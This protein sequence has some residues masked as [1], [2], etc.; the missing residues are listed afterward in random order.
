MRRRSVI[1]LVAL[2]SSLLASCRSPTSRGGE[3][4]PLVV[5]S[6]NVL[7]LFDA[8]DDGNEYPGYSVAQGLW[9]EAK[10][11]ARLESIA[12][13]A[14]RA[15]RPAGRG[16]IGPDILCL[17]EIEKKAILDDLVEGPLAKYGYRW[18]AFARARGSPIGLGI[19][20]RIP[21]KGAR[22]WGLDLGAGRERP[23]LEAR[24]SWEGSPVAIFLN[25]WKSKV[26]GAESTELSRVQS[27]AL[28]SRAIETERAVEPGLAVV[29]CGDFNEGP[30]EY[31][32]VGGRYA[33]AFMPVDADG[34]PAG[35]ILVAGRSTLAGV[36]GGLAV[37][38]KAEA[39]RFVAY[40]PWEDVEGYSYVHRGVRERIDGF[41]LS[42]DLLDG[43]GI[44]YLD[45]RV[46]KEGLIDGKG[47][48]VPWS[49]STATGFS[50]HLPLVLELAAT[51]SEENNRPAL[52]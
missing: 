26:E 24:I 17:V 12:A 39:G 31:A 46:V 8:V 5:M 10:Y 15:G 18:S 9:N 40:S 45:F 23:I 34:A 14:S 49:N 1:V 41:V 21:L 13:V 20:S 43:E 48:P 7:S 27:A 42:P 3:V 51:R 11:R 47:V 37:G 33:T 16:P 52:P 29:A 30:D 35:S 19:L 4:L 22:A 32:N 38:A 28:L 44:A 25:H 50:D 2:L 6:W 36:T